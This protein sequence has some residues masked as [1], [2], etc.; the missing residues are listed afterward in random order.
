MDAS[1]EKK[2]FKQPFVGKHLVSILQD[3]VPVRPATSAE[4]WK[5]DTY[6]A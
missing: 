4:G 6:H 5:S 1:A 3:T 2:I